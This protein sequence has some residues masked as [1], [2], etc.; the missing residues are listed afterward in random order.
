MKILFF[1]ILIAIIVII[2]ILVHGYL[3]AT[4]DQ[5]YHVDY[6]ELDKEQKLENQQVN[7]PFASHEKHGFGR[8]ARDRTRREGRKYGHRRGRRQSYDDYENSLGFGDYDKRRGLDPYDSSDP[9]NYDNRNSPYFGD[10]NN[11]DD[12]GL[13]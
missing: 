2:A 11:H 1:I 3:K 13:W 5:R 10:D 4:A 8:S 6:S 7:E 9:R 12:D